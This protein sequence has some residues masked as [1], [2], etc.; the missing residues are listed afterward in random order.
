M[1]GSGGVKLSLKDSSTP[2]HLKTGMVGEDIAAKWYLDRGF[3][4]LER[5]YWQKW[6]EIDLIMKQG[7]KVYFIEVKSVS[8]ETMGDLERNVPRGTYRPEENVH[9]HKRQR[10]IRAVET[11]IAEKAY[12][13]DFQ[14]DV[15]T[16]RLVSREKYAAV[17]V[18]EGVELG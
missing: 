17:E 8:H 9:F 7:Q 15:A 10:L 1:R 6:G 11:W 13:G 2:K 4:L 5:N 12:K 18:I 3:E 14:V 16:V